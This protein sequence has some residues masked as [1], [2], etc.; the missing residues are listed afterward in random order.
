MITKLFGFPNM[1]SKAN[2]FKP[3]IFEEEI[4]RKHNPKAKTV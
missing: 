4:L 3:S 2:Q 1:N